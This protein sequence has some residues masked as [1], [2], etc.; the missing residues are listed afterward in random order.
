MGVLLSRYGSRGDVGLTVGLAVRL[1][2]PGTQMRVCPPPD[3]A[4]PEGCAALVA[5]AMV[6]AG[7]WR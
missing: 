7:G 1:G 6:P 2:A 3:C 5:T 4:A